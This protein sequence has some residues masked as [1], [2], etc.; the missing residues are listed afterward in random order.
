M[1]L[2]YEMDTIVR[3]GNAMCRRLRRVLRI[4]ISDED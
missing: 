1:P 2:P 4:L 3:F